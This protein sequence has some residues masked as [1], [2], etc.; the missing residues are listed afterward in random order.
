MFS[1]AN[2]CPR[3]SLMR[4]VLL[5]LTAW[6]LLLSLPT[7]AQRQ[8][9]DLAPPSPE[10]AAAVRETIVGQ[11]E[12]FQA[13][14]GALAM[15]FAVPHVTNFFPTPEI[16]MAMVRGGYGPL[17]RPQSFS[18]EGAGVQGDLVLQTLR[19]TAESGE[20]VLAL[21]ELVRQADGRWLIAGVRT[22]P[23]APRELPL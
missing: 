8:I 15:T 1:I 21:Y 7:Q 2:K 19:V 3:S 18:F 5:G 17:Y 23:V 16:F 14:D 20:T 6:F 4:A 11:L 12:A 22:V 13:D 10:I 9:T